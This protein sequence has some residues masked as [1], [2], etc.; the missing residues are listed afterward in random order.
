MA[1]APDLFRDRKSLW[2]AETEFLLKKF[3]SNYFYFDFL[4][5]I[6]LQI[7][8]PSPLEGHRCPQYADGNGVVILVVEGIKHRNKTRGQRNIIRQVKAIERL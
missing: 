7:A 1:I 5:R 3:R 2:K 4:G 6:A 8:F